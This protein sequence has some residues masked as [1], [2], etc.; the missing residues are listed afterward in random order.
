VSERLYVAYYRVSTHRQGVSGLGLEAQEEAVRRYLAGSGG[1]LLAELTEIE[2]GKGADA[3]SKRPQ[4]REGLGLCQAQG[5]V[6]LIAKLDRLARTVRLIAELMESRVKFVACDMPEAN[7]LTIHIMAAFAEHEAK[8]IS[9][10][11]REAL[12]RAKARG[13]RLGITAQTNLKPNIEA[14][15][16]AACVFAD[17]LRGQ[18]TGFRLRGLTQ[19]QMV[20]E[21]NALGVGSPRGGRWILRQLQRVLSRL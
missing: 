7:D 18:I 16:A 11:T 3:L 2:T 9:E 1:R 14:R 8:R 13:I 20:A 17:R 5:A 12:S 10:R 21:L 19:R 15:R 4:L 6:L